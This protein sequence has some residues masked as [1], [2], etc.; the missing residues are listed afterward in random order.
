MPSPSLLSD[1]GCVTVSETGCVALVWEIKVCFESCKEASREIGVQGLGQKRLKCF[2]GF[3]RLRTWFVLMEF[4]PKFVY[5]WYMNHETHLWS[6]WISW[7]G[8]KCI[9]LTVTLLRVRACFGCWEELWVM[10]TER[11][12]FGDIND[13][14][15]LAGMCQIVNY[16]VEL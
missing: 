11:G 5:Q 8:M 15:S 7:E 13:I 14:C 6:V 9:L 1:A 2:C 3:G 4:A 16:C 12:H 10:T